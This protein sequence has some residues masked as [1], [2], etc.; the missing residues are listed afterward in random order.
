MMMK[1]KCEELKRFIETTT[2][3]KSE[4]Y[5]ASIKSMME[6]TTQIN[7]RNQKP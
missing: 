5:N 7:T 6:T 1:T 4:T 3:L 2:Q